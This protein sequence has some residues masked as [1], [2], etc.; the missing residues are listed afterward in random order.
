MP[1]FWEPKRIESIVRFEAELAPFHNWLFR[2]QSKAWGQL[3]PSIDRPPRSELNRRTKLS[4][5]RHA[6]EAF[7][8]HVRLP[9][10]QSVRQAMNDP[11]IALMVLRHFDVPT[12]ILDWSQSP[13]VAG[14]FAC[15]AHGKSDGE[16]WAFDEPLYESEGR[17]QWVVGPPVTQDGEFHPQFNMFMPDL[18][19]IDWFTCAFYL[20]DE[21]PRQHAQQG[22]FSLTA[23][24]GTDHVRY[25]ARL[26]KKPDTCR[27]FI[28]PA[29]LKTRLSAHLRD[30][31]GVQMSSL[32]PDKGD[33]R[34]ARAVSA[35]NE[36][37]RRNGAG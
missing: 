1:D 9:A 35:A 3:V 17:K 15:N 7:R 16:I 31:H 6:I 36:V 18:R 10:N 25:I 13:H 33:D 11:H 32:F 29:A 21:F 37:F 23:R 20:A 26:L 8:R 5:E 2:G 22:A 14:F 34:Q 24:F 19:D 30:V 28:I 27:R 4:L 12:R